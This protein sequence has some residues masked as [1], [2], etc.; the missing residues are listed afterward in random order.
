MNIIKDNFLYHMILFF[1]FFPVSLIFL[2]FV[3]EEYNKSTKM[4]FKVIMCYFHIWRISHSSVL[5]C[6]AYIDPTLF[7]LLL[8]LLLLIISDVFFLFFVFVLFF[9]L[10]INVNFVCIFFICILQHYSI[11]H[12]FCTFNTKSLFLVRSMSYLVKFECKED[13]LKT[14][15]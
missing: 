14:F 7:L 10:M 13:V 6:L 3:H 1:S 2:V 12:F 15:K 4:E 11:S 8:L 9:K 5:L